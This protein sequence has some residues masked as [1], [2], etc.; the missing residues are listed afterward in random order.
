MIRVTTSSWPSRPAATPTRRRS[1]S[2]RPA[3][4]SSRAA[5]R[6]FSRPTTTTCC[7]RRRTRI[8]R[9]RARSR[10]RCAWAAWPSAS[11]SIPARSTGWRCTRRSATWRS[12]RRPTGSPSSSSRAAPPTRTRRSSTRCAPFATAAASARSSGAT[13]SSGRSPRRSSSCRR[14]WASTRGPRSSV[15]LAG[16]AGGTKTLLALFEP[17]D[18]APVLVREATVPS[19]EFD[20]LEAIVE[21]FLAAGPRADITAACV[22]IAGPV[23]D[24]RGVTPNL[25]WVVD[26]GRLAAVIHAPRVRLLNDLE[27][28]AHGIWALGE[29]EL[30]S[31]QSGALRRG[32]LA[33]IAAGTGLGEAI[34]V[35]DGRIRTVIATEGGHT[36]FGPRGELEEDLLRYLRKEFGHASYERVLSGPGLVNVYRF[37]R[38]TG[39]AGEASQT[40]ERMAAGDP[41][42]VIT[43]HGARGRCR[44]RCP[45]RRSG[46]RRS[47]S[48]CARSASPR[49]A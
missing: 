16:D 42:A 15:I 5:C 19:R 27:A 25:P 45:R 48:G 7:S 34:V 6:S 24:G 28:T 39:V 9:S 30:V 46:P 8:R 12:R 23:V 33:V 35:G 36:D 13:R 3:R 37:L 18:G 40:A 14:S 11:R 26:E 1:A 22:G 44:G 29:D 41:A 38:D 49:S 21:R 2:S 4:V 20:S 47:P 43:D 17:G 10:T 31:L 32:N